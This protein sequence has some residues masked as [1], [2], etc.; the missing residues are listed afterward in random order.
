M[1]TQL[2]DL[3]FK[4]ISPETAHHFG[5]AM[6]R[7]AAAL[8]G[9]ARAARA[10]IG[11]D[12]ALTVSAL[13]TS[14][15]SPLGVA[16]GFD[17]NG[18]G[19][20]A[21]GLLGF[22][23]VEVGT[24][25]GQA[26]PGNPEPRLFRL[27]ADRSLINRMGFNNAGSQALAEQLRRRPKWGRTV[28][29]ISIGKTK[30]VEPDAAADD[31]G[32]SAARL[33]TSG[34]YFAVNVSS[35]NTPGLRDL[36]AV[37]SLRPILQRVRAELDTA[38]PA[39]HVPLL[40]KIAPDL[41]DA[42]IDAVADLA[43]ELGLDGIIATN[44][45]ISRKGLTAS[46]TEVEAIGAGGL[47]G[48]PL[49]GRAQEVMLRLYA[50]TQGRLVLIGAGGIT[51]PEDAWQRIQA[52]ATL[53]QG[54]TGFIYGG[55]LWAVRINRGLARR[56][57]DAGYRTIADAV[58]AL[59]SADEKRSDSDGALGVQPRLGGPAHVGGPAELLEHPDQAS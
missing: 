48:P 27:S 7:T 39:S 45:T 21:L 17:K 20:D 43:V 59:H 26:Q 55:P 4:R 28:I 49:T 12:P 41:A 25:T 8:P 13:G 14:F 51:T 58:G 22:S 31:Y 38:S 9:A 11:P 37:E 1:Y 40:V 24:V 6:I 5:F 46:A 57:R 23:H 15:T 29:G 10:L 35:P 54:Y 19:P 53:I 33:A 52:G 56:A 47:S 44:T 3:V 32:I 30:A 50:R 34:A 42:D 16:A 2:F 18:I 36:Q